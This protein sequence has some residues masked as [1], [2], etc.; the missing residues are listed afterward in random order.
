MHQKETHFVKNSIEASIRLILF[1][2]LIA[3]CLIILMPFLSILL[4]GIILSVAAAPILFFLRSRFNMSDKW[5]A[6]LITTV[7]LVT[8]ILPSYLLIHSLVNE[9]TD[10]LAKEKSVE[11]TSL[12][13][14]LKGLPVVNNSLYD[15]IKKITSDS[16]VVL[17]EH[18][19]QI[20]T[21]GIA[22]LSFIGGLGIGL[23]HFLASV[24]IA[25][26][27]LAYSK[28]SAALADKLFIRVAG[29]NGEEFSHIAERT[30]QNVTKGIIGVAFIES[31][32]AAFGFF[33]AGVPLA[34]VWTI[35]C[36]MLSIIQIGIVPLA[37]P[38]VIYMF[39]NS[40][41]LT[42]TLLAV[43]L[44]LVYLLEHLL[45]PIL[46]GKGAPVPM[47]IIF[48]GV[49]GG[50]VAGGFIGMFLGAVIFSIAYK[51]F[52]VWLENDIQKVS[53]QEG[54]E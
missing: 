18:A 19:S 45:K 29:K 49:L 17:K 35:V 13:E 12:I 38:I 5:A 47:P 11:L 46:L 20:E 39:Y 21:L 28:K 34:G 1:F 10:F 51:L 26:F 33:M 22:T 48:I 54:I 44:T 14:N 2:S 3:F 41:P 24:V 15:F 32:L 23:I 52:L 8:F 7:A 53:E 37:V 4:G 31:V 16:S 30:I 42:A 36:L 9:F 40:D 50:F 25:G 6:I 43:W 27:F